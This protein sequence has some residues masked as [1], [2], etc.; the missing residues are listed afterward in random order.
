MQLQLHM[1]LYMHL[2][3]HLHMRADVQ[4]IAAG[5]THSMLMKKDGTVWTTGKNENGQL[6]DGTR[7]NRLT[8]VKAAIKGTQR[9]RIQ[10]ASQSVSQSVS[11]LF[12]LDSKLTSNSRN[13]TTTPTKKRGRRPKK[14][15][16]QITSNSN[17]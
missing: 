2:H 4:A 11:Q 7:T 1:H 3:M 16:R 6:A 14:R 10:S 9:A 12:F 8:F 15:E 13:T 5:E 17:E